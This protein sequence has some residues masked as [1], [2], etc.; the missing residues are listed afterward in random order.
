MEQNEFNQSDELSLWVPTLTF[1]L[2]VAVGGGLV[3]Q[4]L[5]WVVL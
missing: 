1:L 2:G 3:L 4:Y 5:N